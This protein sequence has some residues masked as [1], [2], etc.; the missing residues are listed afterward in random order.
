MRAGEGSSSTCATRTPMPSICGASGVAEKTTCFA[1]Y[2]A[3]L[4]DTALSA[5]ARLLATTFKRCDCALSAEPAISKTL[6]RDIGVFR[7]LVRDSLLVIV[8][9][10]VGPSW[11]GSHASG[12]ISLL[13]GD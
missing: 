6:R 11:G 4:A 2:A 8:A 5:F 3:P 13:T 10:I 12:I 1:R 9:A 7:F